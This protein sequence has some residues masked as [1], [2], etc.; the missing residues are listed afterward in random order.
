S[1]AKLK[2]AVPPIVPPPLLTATAPLAT[3]LSKEPAVAALTLNCTMP[4]LMLMAP[5]K[6][7][8]AVVFAKTTLLV[9]FMMMLPAVPPA[10][11]VTM[12]LTVIV[13][14]VPVL[15]DPPKRRLLLFRLIA[16]VVVALAPRVSVLVLKSLEIRKLDE[17]DME[18][19]S[20]T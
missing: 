2:A 16:V 4:V 5:R 9:P 10:L 14:V 3:P 17:S 20:A 8:F 19:L 18:T 6:V 13:F 12:S 1:S 11:S 7:L 15:G